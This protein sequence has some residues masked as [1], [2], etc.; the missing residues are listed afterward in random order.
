MNGF[1]CGQI[2]VLR[3]SSTLYEGVGSCQ[4]HAATAAIERS[5]PIHIRG[6]MS[7]QPRASTI[8]AKQLGVSG[9]RACGRFGLNITEDHQTQNHQY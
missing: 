7:K 4:P 3:G 9:Q 1:W 6:V 8:I 2:H 5:C